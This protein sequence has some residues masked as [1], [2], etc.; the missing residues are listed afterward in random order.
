[1]DEVGKEVCLGDKVSL[2]LIHKDEEI[3]NTVNKAKI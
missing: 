2:T 3:D 1:V